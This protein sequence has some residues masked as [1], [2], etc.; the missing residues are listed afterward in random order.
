MPM[1]LTD[2]LRSYGLKKPFNFRIAIPLLINLFGLLLVI[3]ACVFLFSY[4]HL[5]IGTERF[6]FFCYLVVLLVIAAGLSRFSSLSLALFFWCAVELSLALVSNAFHKGEIMSSL[7]P[8]NKF[9][10]PRDPRY[11]YHPVLGMVNK[12]SSHG[13]WH[14]DRRNTTWF[15]RKDFPVNPS[16]FYDNNFDHNSLGFRGK[17]LTASDLR[18]ELIFVHGGST[19]YDWTV[20]QGAT[21][22]ERLDAELNHQFT[23][24]NL[25]VVAHSTA[26][27][28]IHTAFYH[29]VL[30]KKPRCAVYYVGWNDLH[31][32]NIPNLDPTYANRLSLIMHHFVRT[33]DLWAAKYSP[34]VRLVDKALR[35]RF[36]NVP[37]LSWGSDEHSAS[38]IAPNDTRLEQ[39]FVEHVQTIAAINS[40]RG[41][42]TIF[43][44]QILNRELFRRRPRAKDFSRFVENQGVWPMQNHFNSILERTAAGA[45]AKYIDAG[46]DN[47]RNNDFSDVGHFSAD[48]SRK[49]ANL[50]AKQV[51]TYCQ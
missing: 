29:S 28:L 31:N 5:D 26:Q 10:M 23:I 17:E 2:F 38:P 45:G 51:E 11:A 27:H 12:P 22:T 7:F 4:H 3:S 44:G 49:F 20:T 15:Q 30:D 37:R 32:L 46:I 1:S 35:S 41:T 50:V 24:V 13:E 42:K 8:E 33:P 25:G 34:A 6:Y 40:S 16:F 48:G 19:T 43:I 47:F 18:K 21:W 14:V 39:I 36:D 9:A